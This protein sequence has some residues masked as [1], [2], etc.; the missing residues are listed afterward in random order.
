M[1]PK[2]QF[3]IL[4]YNREQQSSILLKSLTENVKCPREDFWVTYLCNGSLNNEWP[5]KWYNDGVIDQLIIRRKNTGGSWG[6]VDLASICQSEYAFLL[7]NDQ[8]LIREIN[9]NTVNYFIESL[10]AK[11]KL[12]D[13]NGFQAGQEN[14]S[15][16][17]SFVK[18]SDYRGWVKNL[19]NYGPGYEGGEHNEHEIQEIFKKNK[20]KIA[21]FG[22]FFADNGKWSFRQNK[23]GSTWKHQTDTKKQYYISGEI[24]EKSVYPKFTDEEWNYVLTN[25][26]WPDGQIPE[27]EKEHSFLFWKE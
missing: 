13:L 4:D 8:Y 2:F 21:N 3:L 19:N 14:F 24:K 26:S 23:D 16:R 25:Q 20:Y 18:I 11:F 9:N 17:A 12:I 22:L 7:Q 27:R 15:D 1:I 5:F 10:E 6:M